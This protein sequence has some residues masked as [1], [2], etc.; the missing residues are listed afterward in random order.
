MTFTLYP[1]GDCTHCGDAINEQHLTEFVA[2][3]SGLGSRPVT[4][5]VHTESGHERCTGRDTVAERREGAPSGRPVLPPLTA[6]NVSNYIRNR[7]TPGTAPG[8]S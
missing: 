8:L 5:L 6:E 1:A 2:G 3:E 7:H 4:V